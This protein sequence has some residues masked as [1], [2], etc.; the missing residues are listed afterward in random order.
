LVETR[1]GSGSLETRSGFSARISG[2][3]RTLKAFVFRVASKAEEDNIFFMA[4]AITFNFLVGVVPLILLFVGISGFILTTRFPDPAAELIEF[5]LHNLPTVG[6]EVNLLARVEELV[7]TLVD[8]RAGFSLVGLLIFVW[9]A[10][11]LVG[12]LRTA[13]REVFDFPQGRG[14]VAG[15]IFDAVMVVVGGLLFVVNVGITVVLET[16]QGYG[17]DLLGLEGSG[18]GLVEQTTSQILAFGSIWMLFF[19]SYRYL[20]PRRVPGRTAAVAATFTGALFEVSKY[21]FSWYVTNWAEFRTVYGGLTGVAILFFW[22]YY[23]SVVF[24]LG[25]EVA[26]VY[27]MNRTRRLHAQRSTQ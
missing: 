26:Q 27:S 2:R 1:G 3:F 19:L 10:T 23:I 11:R 25:G 6:G 16:V 8:D 22:I 7:R 21:L 17:I 18:L 4:G 15:K 13:L 9:I 12:T 24:I 20:P 5:L 14:I